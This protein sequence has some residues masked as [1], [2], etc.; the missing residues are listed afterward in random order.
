MLT[1]LRISWIL[2]QNYKRVLDISDI[3]VGNMK[4]WKR[5]ETPMNHIILTPICKEITVHLLA[6]LMIHTISHRTILFTDIHLIKYPHHIQWA[7]FQLTKCNKWATLL[8][9]TKF[10][11]KKK[12]HKKCQTNLQV[13]I[14]LLV[15]KKIL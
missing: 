3:F 14:N 10:P 12:K 5:V 9:P 8:K 4:N 6:T 2:Q 1:K 13:T 7:I 11:S 15:I